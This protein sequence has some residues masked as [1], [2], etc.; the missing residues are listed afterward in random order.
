MRDIARNLPTAL[1]TEWR[2]ITKTHEF[3]PKSA[4]NPLLRNPFVATLRRLVRHRTDTPKGEHNHSW[5]QVQ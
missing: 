5:Q 1:C 2:E 3:R 4:K